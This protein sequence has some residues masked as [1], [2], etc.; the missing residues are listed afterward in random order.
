MLSSSKLI[1]LY[2]ANAVGVLDDELVDDVGWRLW[3]R[4]ADVVRVSN[5]RVRCPVCGTELQVRVSGRQPDDVVRCQGCEWAVTPR[6]WHESWEN[7]DLN[8]WCHE[9]QRFVD[10]WPSARSVGDRMVMIDTVVHALHVSSR[11]DSPGNFAARNFL[12]G[13][14]PKVVALLDE[15]AL[16]PG[17]RVADG[18]RRRWSEAREVYRNRHGR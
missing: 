5:G 11:E 16:G 14:R 10:R 3:E 1:R 7:R 6:K 15:L 9:F 13:S 18:A 12:E 4:L 2:E 17:S 8:G